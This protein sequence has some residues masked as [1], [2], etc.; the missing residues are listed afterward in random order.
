MHIAQAHCKG[1]QA[2][3]HIVTIAQ[4]GSQKSHDIITE[5][6]GLLTF[7]VGVPWEVM[8]REVI[9]QEVYSP[10]GFP[11]REVLTW[12]TICEVSPSGKRGLFYERLGGYN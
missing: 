3:K 1:G 12:E 10:G 6:C 5:P 4:P 9:L 11:T 2:I 8:F 7:Y